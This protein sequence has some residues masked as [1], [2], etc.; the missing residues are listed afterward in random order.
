[1]NKRIMQMGAVAV[2][3]MVRAGMAFAA[4]SPGLPPTTMKKSALDNL[5][6]Q[7]VDIAPW[8]YA[9]RAGLAVQEKPEAYL[10]RGVSIGWIRCT[11]RLS[12][13]CHSNS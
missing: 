4:E 5:A 9:W 3:A 7:P 10:C 11:G 6:G 12:P 13:R 2:F 1:M 8:A